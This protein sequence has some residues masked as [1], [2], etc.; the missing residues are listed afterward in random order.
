MNEHTF[1]VGLGAYRQISV[2]SNIK[3]Y[4][5]DNINYIFELKDEADVCAYLD[6]VK[7]MA[8]SVYEMA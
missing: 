2:L 1:W 6:N 5:G 7:I 3:F 4:F 8:E